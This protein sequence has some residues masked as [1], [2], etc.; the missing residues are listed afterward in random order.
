MGLNL[1]LQRDLDWDF[2][3]F[4]KMIEVKPQ[5]ENSYLKKKHF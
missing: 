5:V 3:N 4:V 2:V 1:T